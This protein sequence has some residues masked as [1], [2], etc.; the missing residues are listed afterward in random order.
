MAAEKEAA[1]EAG[2]E[3]DGPLEVQ[4]FLFRRLLERAPGAR[5]ELLSFR[6]HLLASAASDA[7]EALKVG[8]PASCV[9][10]GGILAPGV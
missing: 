4:G 5:Q 10:T 6:D 9:H 2:E 1:R 3:D 8:D 7:D